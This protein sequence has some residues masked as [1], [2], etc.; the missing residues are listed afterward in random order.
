MAFA[1]V[2][3]SIIGLC[4]AFFRARMEGF[5]TRWGVLVHEASHLAAG[6][7]DHATPV[8]ARFFTDLPAFAP[9]S[10]HNHG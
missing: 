10:A 5:D 8:E 3:R 1:S 6:T 9:F 2:P 4:P 7:Q